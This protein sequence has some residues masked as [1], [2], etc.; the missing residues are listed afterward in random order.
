MLMSPENSR[1]LRPWDAIS[2][3]RI[4]SRCR[5]CWISPPMP[6]STP[7]PIQRASKLSANE[8]SFLSFSGLGRSFICTLSTPPTG[9]ISF[10]TASLLASCGVYNRS[11]GNAVEFTRGVVRHSLPLDCVLCSRRTD[12]GTE[13]EIGVNKQGELDLFV[14]N[15]SRSSSKR[16]SSWTQAVRMESH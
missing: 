2:S 1:E 5:S 14:Y 15:A 3:D 4:H 9:L 16:N 10:L 7:I 11:T 13:V 6:M 12:S 8:L